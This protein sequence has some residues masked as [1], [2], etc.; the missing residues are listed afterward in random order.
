VLNIYFARHYRTDDARC[1]NSTQQTGIRINRLDAQVVDS[2]SGSLMWS[3]AG[4]SGPQAT[5]VHWTPAS[6]STFC[7]VL[8]MW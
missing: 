1:A 4:R 6:M 2:P 3:R 5:E 7:C 8:T